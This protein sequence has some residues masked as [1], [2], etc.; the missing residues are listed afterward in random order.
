MRS[1]ISRLGLILILRNAKETEGALLMSTKLSTLKRIL[2]ILLILLPLLA[3]QAAPLSAAPLPATLAPAPAPASN[4]AQPLTLSNGRLTLALGEKGEIV[5]L[6][7]KATQLEFIARPALPL[8]SLA[9]SERAKPA[10][11][12][13]FHLSSREAQQVTRTLKTDQGRQLATL[14]YSGFGAW[15]VQVRCTA[16]LRP[17]DPLA[18]WRLEVKIPAALTLEDVRFPRVM[19]RAPLGAKAEGHAALLGS[20]KGG[21]V[22]NPVWMKPGSVVSARQPGNLAAQFG[23]YYG[24]R[25]GFYTAAHDGKGY[26]KEISLQRAAEGLDLTW[27]QSC[28]T[29]GTFAL[30]YD[31]VMTT[32]AGAGPS[33][34][35][36]WRDAADLYKAWAL[37]QP[38][39]AATF[40]ERAD[41]PAW[42]KDGPAMVRF[43]R[44]WL[45][46][47]ERIEK[48]VAEYFRRGFPQAP[49]I[50]AY[51]GWE[52]VDNWVT[53]DYFP[54]HPSNAQFADLVARTRRLGAH[55]FPWPSG[56]HWT[57]TYDKQPDGSFAWDDR[58]R[59]DEVARAHAVHN[60]DGALYLRPASWLKGG[61]NACLC[62]GDPWT[63]DW[64]NQQVCAP[65]ARLGCEM[66]QVD[67][68]VGGN[69]PPCY[70]PG[71]AHPRGPGLWMTEVFERQLRTMLQACR[72]IEPGAVVCFEE[73]NERFIQ[74]AGIQDYRD[75]EAPL[76]WASV[77]NYLYHE[78]LP[79]FQSNPRAGDQ[80]MNAW[81][82]VNGQIPHMVPSLRMGEGPALLGGGF[83]EPAGKSGAFIGWDQVR[84]YQ[85]EAWNGKAA[86]D[87]AER[88]DGAASLR[89]E[90]A[91]PTDVVQVSQNVPIDAKAF[92]P[93]GKYRLGAWIKTGSLARPNAINLALQ[94]ADGKFSGVGRIPLPEAG[95]GWVRRSADFTVPAGSDTLRIMIHVAGPARVWVDGVTL[96]AVRP[97]GSLA[98]VRRSY[99]PSDRE[100]MR[101]WVELYHGAGRP[102]LEFGRMLH[103]PRLQC[104]AL[105]YRSQSVPAVM[106]NAFRAPDGREAVALANASATSQTATLDWKGQQREIKLEPAGLRLIE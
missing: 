39:C 2:G 25:A 45:D 50:T 84:G 16:A 34:P 102:W 15:G 27:S 80:V 8:F 49:L 5:S 106:H 38:W 58:K 36:D 76:P 99:D 73:P 57:R 13:V 53:P 21:V 52:K 77:F 61:E 44:N 60:R 104:A 35:P 90:N 55:A 62:P 105:A 70:H 42:L 20:T 37:T 65:L 85:G 101:R 97:D 28:F 29:S 24:D 89:L 19:L 23:C 100:F 41:V 54:V 92:A 71:H 72:R 63:I 93:G 11:S 74:F 31:V 103:P 6:V 95:A 59:F 94:G 88:H 22:R 17:D 12:A 48:W 68:V 78:F 33:T 18:R 96:E 14:E 47:P 26:R 69:F 98:E 46:Q 81:C 66:I 4:S 56:Y 51:W 40:A 32:F 43:S 9:F 67:Q 30:D 86:R 1:M 3:L 91:A 87:E 79:T 7:D 10:G 64:W 83:E 82:M 75:C